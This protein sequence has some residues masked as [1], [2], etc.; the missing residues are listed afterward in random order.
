[1]DELLS[2][3]WKSVNSAFVPG[4]VTGRNTLF[5]AEQV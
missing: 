2:I 5:I 1:M 3:S 4:G